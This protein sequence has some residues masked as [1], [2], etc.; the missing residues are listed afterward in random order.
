MLRSALTLLALMILVVPFA[1]AHS[2]VEASELETLFVKDELSD[3]VTATPGMGY[4]LGEFYIGEAY[5]PGLGDG[6]Y[7][8]TTLFSTKDAPTQGPIEVAFAFTIVGERV[9]RI[10]LVADPEW[11][12]TTEI[13]YLHEPPPSG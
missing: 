10:E 9:A 6:F 13:T 3:T 2:L 7:V 11:L 1:A 12:A 5:Q 4:D 8:H